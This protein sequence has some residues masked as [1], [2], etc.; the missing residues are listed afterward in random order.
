MWQFNGILVTHDT[1]ERICPN[2]TDRTLIRLQLHNSK[3]SHPL[4][5]ISS[6]IS[7]IHPQ[8]I[9]LICRAHFSIV[10]ATAILH[11]L[12][13]SLAR[14]TSEYL[15]PEGIKLTVHLQGRAS[16]LWIL[17]RKLPSGHIPSS[18]DIL[19]NSSEEI[20]GSRWTGQSAAGITCS[21]DAPRVHSRSKWLS[22][23]AMPQP[24]L[25]VYE[26]QPL[27]QCNTPMPFTAITLRTGTAAKGIAYSTKPGWSQG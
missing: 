4:F 18:V 20:K 6:Y 27:P 22:R 21:G 14:E 8:P 16:E 9:Y 23:W 25:F 1:L 17:N 2:R 15:I 7:T 12:V 3:Y 13:T 24:M 26:R 19:N 11:F 5:Y 10:R